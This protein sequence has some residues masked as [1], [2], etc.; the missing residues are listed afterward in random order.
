MSECLKDENP[1][2]GLKYIGNA[3]RV[4]IN[5]VTNNLNDS[6]MDLTNDVND[7]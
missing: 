2:E 6:I 3:T 4:T 7:R 5:D 1:P